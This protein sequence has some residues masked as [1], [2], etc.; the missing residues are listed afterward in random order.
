MD[1]GIA[2]GSIPHLIKHQ[3]AAHEVTA[4]RIVGKKIMTL[5]VSLTL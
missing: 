4:R 1:G 2:D 3:S 5:Y